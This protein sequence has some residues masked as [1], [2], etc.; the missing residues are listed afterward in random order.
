MRTLTSGLAHALAGEY[1]V[2]TLP[3]RA[4]RRFEAMKRADPGLAAIV[5]QWERELVPLAERVPGIEPPARVWSAIQARIGTRQAPRSRA[6][7][8][9]GA[10]V[11][12]A[13]GGLGALLLAAILWLRPLGGTEPLFV[14]VLSDPQSNPHVVVTMQAPDALRLR[15]MKPVDGTDGHD[16]ELWVIPKA[17][18][19]RSLGVMPNADGDVLV[20][21]L[22]TDPR[23]EGAKAL[24][25][26]LEPRGGSPTGQ[27]TGPVILNGSIAYARST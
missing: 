10:R 13:F 26:S 4:R 3:A 24:A 18:S 27:P 17:G 14:A 5:D 6:P 21:I 7:L 2:G 8:A 9:F 1:V 16:L 20:R 12:S 25:V 22:P 11:A 19:P 15:M 23:M